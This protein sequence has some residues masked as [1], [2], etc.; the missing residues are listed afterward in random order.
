MKETI[1]V[2]TGESVTIEHLEALPGGGAR[3]ELTTEDAR[4]WHVDVTRG[5]E[6]EI[7]TSGAKVSSPTSTNRVAGRRR[8]ATRAVLRRTKP[9][10]RHP[11][12]DTRHPTLDTNRIT[13][14]REACAGR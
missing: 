9:G 7:V 3:F 12:P 6:T 2:Y 13:P 8:I 4:K 14:R 11:T 1:E 5:G 10:T